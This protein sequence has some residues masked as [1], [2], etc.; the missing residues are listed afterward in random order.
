MNATQFLLVLLV[1]SAL[2]TVL[3]PTLIRSA[4]GLAMTSAVLTLLLFQMDAPL[5]GVFE[6]SVCAGLI[7]VVFVS[8]ISLTRPLQPGVQVERTEKRRTSFALLLPICAAVF[9]L[10]YAAQYAV[11]AGTVSV[12]Q[13]V[14]DV[15]W[16]TRRLDLVGQIIVIFVGIFGV[17]IL[18]RD[19]NAAQD[20]KEVAQ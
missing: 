12:P 19:R 1:L 6:L 3:T 10:V 20:E 14:R 5:A 9:G 8:V 17:V 13:T 18:F 15:L 11:D 7:T 2:W 16:G 4:I